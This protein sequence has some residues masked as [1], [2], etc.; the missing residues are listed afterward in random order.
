MQISILIPSY[1]RQELLLK[2]LQSL[3]AQTVKNFCVTVIDNGSNP[4]I[5]IDHFE[6]HFKISLSRNNHNTDLKILINNWLKSVESDII[7]ILAD[8]DI[9]LPKTIELVLG[10]FKSS[11]DIESLGGGFT[12]FSHQHKITHAKH[13]Y[14][15][16]L[17]STKHTV[18]G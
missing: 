11:S 8:D 1:N 7:L 3:N 12:K 18:L 10:C 17:Y 9:L 2:N 13:K 6:A 15:N 4:P 16:Q 14:S 5:N